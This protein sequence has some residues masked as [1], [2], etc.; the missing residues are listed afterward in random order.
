[1]ASAAALSLG[2]GKLCLR[3]K[4]LFTELASAGSRQ[5]GQGVIRNFL[6]SKG[7]HKAI[8]GSFG[9]Y[10]ACGH[11]HGCQQ[12]PADKYGPLHVGFQ[13]FSSPCRVRVHHSANA[14]E[15]DRSRTSRRTRAFGQIAQLQA[16]C[17][18]TRHSSSG[19][20]RRWSSHID[21]GP[22]S[23][24]RQS[25]PSRRH[26]RRPHRVA[27]RGASAEPWGRLARVHNCG[28]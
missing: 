12:N 27:T 25:T 22:L 11:K 3:G 1:M 15:R 19:A 16:R 26:G 28:R 21:T 2:G 4:R 9:T 5:G 10:D 7:F 18:T 23:R 20:C 14:K 17:R 6:I 24:I 13:P 8:V